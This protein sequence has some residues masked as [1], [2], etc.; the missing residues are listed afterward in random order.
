VTR[1]RLRKAAAGAGAPWRRWS[2]RTRMVVAIAVLAA[3]GIVVADL[4]GLALLRS[5]LTGRIDQQLVASSAA[6][7]RPTGPREPDMP[8]PKSKFLPNLGPDLRVYLFGPSGTLQRTSGDVTDDATP[9]LGT[10]AILTGHAGGDPYTVSD[11]KGGDSW[12]VIVAERPGGAGLAVVAVSLRQ[13]NATAARLTAIDAA[14]TAFVLLL[15][16]LAAAT[17]VRLGLAPLTRMER[18]AQEIAGGDLSKRVEDVDPHTEAGR[19]GMALNGMLVQIE[20]ALQA[21]TASE[22]R[23]RRFLADASHELRTPLTS[24]QGFA[25]LYRRGGARPGPELDEAMSRI[26]GE[27]ARMAMLVGDLLLL[28]RLDQERPLDRAPVDLLAIAADAVRDAHARVPGRFVELVPGPEASTVDGDEARLRQVA[29]NLIANALQYAPVPATITVSVS[30]AV[31]ATGPA[32]AVAVA[33]TGPPVGTP[34]AVLEVADTGPG[35]TPEQAHHAFERLYR[36]DPS[37]TRSSAGAGLGL[38]IVAAIVA[39]HD[40]RVELRTGPGTGASFRVILPA[41]PAPTPEPSPQW[42][43]AGGR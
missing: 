12:R 27:A 36:A 15:L 25:E 7:D 18:V 39:A 24:I 29:T 37:R 38:S 20:A 14:V 23:L 4:A 33:G 31:P 32:G 40:G 41:H 11:T 1:G 10:F 19:L 34:A 16:G 28:A 2:L 9:D 30:G 3:I 6:F 26:E 43:M 42:T 17:V 22:D 5:Y 8:G 35:M 13:V 21:R